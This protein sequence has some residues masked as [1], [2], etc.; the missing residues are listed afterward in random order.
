MRK[1]NRND[2]DMNRR[3]FLKTAAVTGAALCVPTVLSKTM[4]T[5]KAANSSSGTS[6]TVGSG[7]AAI[8]NHRTL[9]SGRASMEVSAM[10][11]GCMGLNYHRSQHPDKKQAIALVHEAVERGVTLFDTA[12]SYGPYKNELLMGE[13]LKGYGDRVFVTSKFGH[14]FVNGVQ[15]KSEEDSCRRTSV[16]CVRN[17]CVVWGWKRSVCFTSTG[18]ILICLWRWWPKQCAN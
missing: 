18:P 14:K 13:A 3:G 1:E 11:F 8:R 6:V 15:V 4:A 12:E 7:M 9:G 10:G 5:E 16:R 17:R 2:C